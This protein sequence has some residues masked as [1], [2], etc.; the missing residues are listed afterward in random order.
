MELMQKSSKPGLADYFIGYVALFAFLLLFFQNLSIIQ[1]HQA[2]IHKI[3]FVILLVFIIDVV[4]RA[5]AAPDKQQYLLSHW[6]DLIVFVPLLRFIPFVENLPFYV[7]LWQT[8][9]IF[10]LIS[11][12]RRAGRLIAM[13]SFR[14]AQ[15][16]LI[17]FSFAIAVGT[18]L[19]S[20]PAATAAGVKTGFIDALFTATSAT[21]VTGLIVK[22]TATYFSPFGQMVILA[23][24]QLGGLGIM[25]FSV[26]LVMLLK[27]SFGPKE[28]L[29][30]REVLD[31]DLMGNVKSLIVFIFKMTLVLELTGTLL[32]F[33]LWRDSFSDPLAAFYHAFFHSISAF[34]NAGFST[35]SDS[36]VHFNNDLSTNLVIMFL[37]I[38]GGVGFPVI[39]DF[40][41]NLLNIFSRKKDH[42]MKLRVQTRLVLL[43][44]LLLIVIGALLIFA[45]DKSRLLAGLSYDN[46]LLIS[47]FQSVSAR[48]AG[49][50]TVNIGGLSSATLFLMIVLM[51]IGASPGSTGG[52]VKTTTVAVLWSILT[53]AMKQRENVQVFKKSLPDEIVHKVVILFVVSILL[54]VFFALLLLYFEEKP[55]RDVLFETVSAFGTVGLS[56]GLT[57]TLSNGGK[58]VVTL[59]MFIGRLGPLTIGYAFTRKRKPARVVYAEEHVM[60]G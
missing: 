60:I 26:S 33:F 56:T 14:P 25:T 41:H 6:L 21:C 32:L 2:L 27:R 19:L 18:I 13:I 28:N 51:F 1:A 30:M 11:R 16:M 17:S 43:V 59:L 53:S 36:L 22:D 24:I 47:L 31:Q 20:L 38:M 50:N 34:C 57:P 5:V 35:F 42:G 23:L 58:L 48:T 54:V 7:I 12:S 44:S 4:A 37:I 29:E 49:F 55:L 52:G 3:N 15:L 10:M 9:L 40:Y 45:F 8:I 39:R 46:Q